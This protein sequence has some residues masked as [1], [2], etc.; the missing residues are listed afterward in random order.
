MTVKQRLEYGIFPIA[1][2]RHQPRDWGGFQR[3]S[4]LYTPDESQ[5]IILSWIL[6]PIIAGVGEQFSDFSFGEI[7]FL[8]ICLNLYL[9]WEIKK[10]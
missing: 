10:G 4:H 1:S 6:A 9:I 5:A 7:L 8:M 3:F 2:R